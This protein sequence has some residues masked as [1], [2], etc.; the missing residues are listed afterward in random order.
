MA[1]SS[2]YLL[3]LRRRAVRMVTEVRP[4]YDTEWAVMKVVA[5]K[6][7]SGTTETLRMGTPLLERS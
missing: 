1:R 4:D 7:G 3:E 2:Q 5:V 6:P